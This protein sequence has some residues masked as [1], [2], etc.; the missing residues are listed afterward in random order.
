VDDSKGD[1]DRTKTCRVARRTPLHTIPILVV[2][3]GVVKIG[4][5]KI[6]SCQDWSC[7]DFW[8]EF[9][10]Q[11]TT[12]K[13]LFLKDR[14]KSGKTEKTFGHNAHARETSIEDADDY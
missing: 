3:I 11:A 13:T 4:V 14:K 5:V 6:W 1:I 10:G 7:Q 9:L 2:K 12:P 8:G